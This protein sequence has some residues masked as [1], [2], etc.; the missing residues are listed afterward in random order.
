MMG[1]ACNLSHLGGREEDLNLRPIP[2]KTA[3]P[4]LNTTKSKKAG[5]M[6]QVVER[7]Q[8]PGPKFKSQYCQRE[9]WGR[10]RERENSIV[11]IYHI[12]FIHL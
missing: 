7:L 4:H 3:R 9:R 10:E 12:L 2:G 6:A 8:V 5:D 11:C 1:H